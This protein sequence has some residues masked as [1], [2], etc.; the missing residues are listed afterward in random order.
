LYLESWILNPESEVR[1]GTPFAEFYFTGG[2]FGDVLF[3]VV[4]PQGL[5]SAATAVQGI[6]F[7]KIG[8]LALK[9]A[10]FELTCGHSGVGFFGS[11]HLIVCYP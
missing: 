4:A 11:L 5:E 2:V 9:V 7:G 8:M 6:E 1:R 10:P 3:E